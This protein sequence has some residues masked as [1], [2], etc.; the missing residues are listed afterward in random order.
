MVRLSGNATFEWQ[1]SA[2]VDPAR[3]LAGDLV[4][5]RHFDAEIAAWSGAVEAIA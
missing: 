2:E 1:G 5:D 4:V 3:G